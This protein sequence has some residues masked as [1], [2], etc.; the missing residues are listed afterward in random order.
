VKVLIIGLGEIGSA[1]FEIVKGV[2]DVVGYDIKHIRDT[3]SMLPSMVDVLHVCFPYTD[4]FTD[5]VVDYV[6][7]TNPKLVLIES[8]VMTGT[9]DAIAHEVTTV[10][11]VHSPVRARRA[12][13][14]KWGL[15]NYTKFIGACDEIGAKLAEDY[16]KSLGFKTH[17][18]QGPLE[19]EFA[20]L[21]H[22]AYFGIML[23][24]NQEMR[25][26]ARDHG[27]NFADLEDFLDSN[28]SE[29]SNQFP[30]PVYDGEPIGGHCIIPGI[31][32]LKQC[33]PSKFLDAV[34]ES[35]EKREQDEN[36]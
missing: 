14:I 22:L 30:V 26:I 18:C 35:N 36:G 11:V 3:P 17:V 24:W 9:T 5:G 12:D 7:R 10:H 33:F 25:R 19:T 1:L 23:G 21:L 15:F 32:L 31:N 2:H 13:G 16:Y 4:E 27:I 29:S 8:T 20:K 6:I 28:T 34:L